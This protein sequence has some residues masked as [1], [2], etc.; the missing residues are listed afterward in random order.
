M[1]PFVEI[2][3]CR[4]VLGGMNLR[5]QFRHKELDAPTALSSELKMWL[6]SWSERWK[7]E[8]NLGMSFDWRWG[9]SH[10]HGIYE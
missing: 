2:L 4:F 5:V 8:R 10:K 6:Q 1:L 9:L 7:L 3:I